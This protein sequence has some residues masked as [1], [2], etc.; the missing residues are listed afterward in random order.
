MLKVKLIFVA[1]VR[2]RKVRQI[3][4]YNNYLFTSTVVLLISMVG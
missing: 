3:K 1:F 4:F 2:V